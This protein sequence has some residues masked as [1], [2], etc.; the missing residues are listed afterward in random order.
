MKMEQMDRDAKQTCTVKGIF[1]TEI[2][3]IDSFL[4]KLEVTANIKY[5]T[6]VVYDK[7]T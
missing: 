6:V 5:Y 1:S 3:D 4:P 7:N 2:H